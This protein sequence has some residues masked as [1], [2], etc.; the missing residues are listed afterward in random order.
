[1]SAAKPT[2]K[3][4]ENGDGSDDEEKKKTPPRPAS[5]R[6]HIVEQ[7]LNEHVGKCERKKC[8]GVWW[9]TVQ[10]VTNDT[11]QQLC[12]DCLCK[13][14]DAYNETIKWQDGSCSLM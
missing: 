2:V 11:T 1:M 10:D 5:R 4:N 12:Y 8:D 7:T 3:T 6:Y 14:E 9:C 13:L